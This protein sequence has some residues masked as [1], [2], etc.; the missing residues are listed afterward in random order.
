MGVI[1]PFEQRRAEKLWLRI[2]KTEFLNCNNVV[3]GGKQF[4]S[5]VIMVLF[6]AIITYVHSLLLSLDSYD[7]CPGTFH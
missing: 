6:I 4:Q 2:A 3:K 5:C 1:V 7:W